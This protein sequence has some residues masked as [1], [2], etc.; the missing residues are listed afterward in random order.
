MKPFLVAAVLTVGL[1][2]S[3]QMQRSGLAGPE[4]ATPGI[5][6]DSSSQSLDKAI[7]RLYDEIG[8]AGVLPRRAFRL[9]MIGQLNLKGDSLLS[10][11]TVITIIDYTKPSTEERLYV[12]DLTTKRLVTTSLVS[13]G[14]NSGHNRTKSFS[15]KPGS[16]KSSLGFY[17]T[18]ETYHGV[19]GYSLRLTGV[20]PGVN[21][22]A[23]RRAI[24]IHGARYVSTGFA[25]RHGRLGRSWGCPALPLGQYREIIDIIK[26][27]A[28]L[29]AYFDD[30][31]YLQNSI[32][33]NLE[34]AKARYLKEV[35][36]HDDD[37]SDR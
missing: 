1:V 19:H 29:F 13:H 26:Q 20:E 21:D 2:W 17:V 37:T 30:E 23:R 25:Q 27:G 34:T 5:L 7:G 31:S 35:I 32:L 4:P 33:L 9:A 36:P 10:S 8:L 16:L 15:N 12:I 24:V 6:N 22:N 14:K 11:D 3:V 28:C 18:A